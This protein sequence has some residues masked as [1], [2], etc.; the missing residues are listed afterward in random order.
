MATENIKKITI[1]QADLPP[2]MV[3]NEGYVFRYRIISDDK[4]R[5]SHWSPIKTIKPEFTFVS[6]ILHHSKTGGDVS[7]L[8]WDP[9]VIKKGTNVIK[10]ADA[11][12]VWVKWHKSDNGDWIH[13]G[14][15]TNNTLS[16]VIPS[17]YTINDIVQASAPNKLTVEIYLKGSPVTRSSSFLRVYQG[18]PYTI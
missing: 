2:L 15:V 7:V 12:D 9:V 10:Q 3:E 13:N 4:N 5:R 8:T 6:K 14:T 11:Y 1:K 17:T 18:G 16:L